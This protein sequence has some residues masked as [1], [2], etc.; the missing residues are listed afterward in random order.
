MA[1]LFLAALKEGRGDPLIVG[2]VERHEI[3]VS[4][5]FPPQK[6]PLLDMNGGDSL[7]NFVLLI[8]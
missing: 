1:E 6:S 7:L 3:S 4:R 2:A 5:N 8:H